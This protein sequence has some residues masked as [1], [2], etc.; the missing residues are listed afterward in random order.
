MSSCGVKHLRRQRFNWRWNWIFTLSSVLC[1]W[2]GGGI[3]TSR[4]MS[5][6][7]LLQKRAIRR[8]N[9][10]LAP[11]LWGS[12]FHSLWFSDRDGIVTS[13][14]WISPQTS[15]IEPLTSQRNWIGWRARAVRCVLR[16]A[17]PKGCASSFP[18]DASPRRAHSPGDWAGP[19][20]GLHSAAD[21]GS[22]E[23]MSP[24]QGDTNIYMKDRSVE[25][26]QLPRHIHPSWSF[27]RSRTTGLCPS[28]TSAEI[29]QEL[30]KAS[31]CILTSGHL[32]GVL[33]NIA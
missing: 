18:S 14:S 22:T 19:S 15:N 17:V 4:M 23:L 24:S 30:E 9:E 28:S 5:K 2:L 13:H 31:S 32:S 6:H 11:W 10:G 21:E 25:L 3:V 33:K 16:L 8:W 29:N 27:R 7:S 20:L 12:S 1:G 26:W